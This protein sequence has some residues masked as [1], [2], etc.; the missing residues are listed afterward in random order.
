MAP[1][2]SMAA[3]PFAVLIQLDDDRVAVED[4]HGGSLGTAAIYTESAKLS[5][6]VRKITLRMEGWLNYV[7]PY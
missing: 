2:T 5:H 6:V 4:I 1:T 3:A 7:N